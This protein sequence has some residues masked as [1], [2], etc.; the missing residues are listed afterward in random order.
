MS[1]SID[2]RRPQ[3]LTTEQ[4]LSVNENPYIRS[5]IEVQN[6]LKLSLKRK[7]AGSTEYQR[8][9]REITNERQRQRNALLENI[10]KNWDNEQAVIDIERQ[11]SGVIFSEDIK[12]TLESNNDRS[13]EHKRLIEVIMTL[14]GTLLEDEIRRR[15][16]AI[17]AVV[18]YCNVEEGRAH[19]PSYRQR[20]SRAGVA[21]GQV[22][23][24]EDAEISEAA[25]ALERA[26]AS[27][28]KE[29]RPKICFICLGN[30][31]L[32][33]GKRT[34]EFHTP[35]ALTKHFRGGHL[36]KLPQQGEIKCNVCEVT[37]EHKMHLQN[38][39]LSVHRTFS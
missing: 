37:L 5:L 18:D 26:K 22:K 20:Q 36:S 33:I 4:S 11:L 21:L 9:S 38:H 25:K 30:Q 28:Y 34:H 27:L 8:L 32:P 13:V 29:K 2:P 17:N 24:K 14:P 39:V 1:R 15:N 3:H 7:T 19:R 23:I 10:K 31:K 6:K 35:A 12:A 16:D